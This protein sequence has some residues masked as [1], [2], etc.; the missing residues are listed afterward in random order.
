MT[1][2]LEVGGVLTL[3]NFLSLGLFL[4]IAGDFDLPAPASFVA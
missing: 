2:H 4:R 3:K 1:F